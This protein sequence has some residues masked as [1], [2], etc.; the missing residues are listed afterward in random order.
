M[1]TP[2]NDARIEMSR[3]ITEGSV[4]VDSERSQCQRRL[5]GLVDKLPIADVPYGLL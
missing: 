3:E 4:L 1:H 2:L 5:L